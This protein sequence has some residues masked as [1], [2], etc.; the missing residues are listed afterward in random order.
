MVA[1]SWHSYGLSQ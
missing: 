1:N